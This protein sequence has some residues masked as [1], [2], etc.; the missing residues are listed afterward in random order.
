MTTM[1]ASV[2]ITVKLTTVLPMAWRH[3]VAGCEALNDG[4]WPTVNSLSV[5][6]G[7]HEG[8]FK[9]ETTPYLLVVI[10]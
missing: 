8:A 6:S 9:S 3:D 4:P 1:G 7:C 10:A 5:C 2:P